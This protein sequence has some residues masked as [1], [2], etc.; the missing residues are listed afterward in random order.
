MVQNASFVPSG[1]DFASKFPLFLIDRVQSTAAPKILPLL[2]KQPH[3]NI[4]LLA[5]CRPAAHNTRTDY[6]HI[7]LLLGAEW[8]GVC[9]RFDNA[10]AAERFDLCNMIRRR[11]ESR[12]YRRCVKAHY[13]NHFVTDIREV[14]ELL[15]CRSKR[16]E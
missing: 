12:V 9:D 1:A 5:P 8:L 16:A 11:A 13:R 10:P 6:K 2:K 14:L 7:E 4:S 15:D 3:P